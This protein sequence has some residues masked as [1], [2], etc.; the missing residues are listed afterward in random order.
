MGPTLKEIQDRE[1]YRPK[2]YNNDAEYN[3]NHEEVRSYSNVEY[4]FEEE[5]GTNFA[6]AQANDSEGI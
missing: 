3:H 5:Q 1:C 6:E 2:G 4:P